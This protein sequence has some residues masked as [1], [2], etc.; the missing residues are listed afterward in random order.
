MDAS[1]V[2]ALSI[3]E[4]VEAD[5]AILEQ[6]RREDQTTRARMLAQAL[7][8]NRQVT[9]EP[10]NDQAALDEETLNSFRLLNIA[11]PDGSESS[12]EDSEEVEELVAEFFESVEVAQHAEGTGDTQEN[13]YNSDNTEDTDN[14]H[15]VETP[16]QQPEDVSAY[17]RRDVS[18]WSPGDDW[19]HAPERSDPAPKSKQCMV[20]GNRYSE[21]GTFEA[22]CGCIWCQNCLVERIEL[23]M[24]DESCFPPECCGPSTI[25]IHYWSP[26]ISRKLLDR[27]LE[28]EVEFRTAN[29]IYCSDKVCS[30]FITPLSIELAGGI[31]RCSRCKKRTCTFCKQDW[32]EGICPVEEETQVVLRLAE[33]EG[34][35]RC[36]KCHHLIE[37]TIG[38]YHM[39]K[40]FHSRYLTI[41][42]L[43]SMKP[44]IAAISSA[45]S[46]V[47]AGRIAVVYIK[48]RT[49]SSI[50]KTII[51]IRKTRIQS[52]KSPKRG[53]RL[54]HYQ[55]SGR[56]THEKLQTSTP[57]EGIDKLNE[58]RT[59][60]IVNISVGIF[61]S[62]T[63]N[64][65]TAVIS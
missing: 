26:L 35:R 58:K 44:A 15:E 42:S 24:R 41:N 55:R 34:W 57:K 22:R 25:L 2:L 39:S 47:R 5:A 32:H 18:G 31:A 19:A 59:I 30:T 56:T 4:A 27:Y 40:S 29:R 7:E 28:K 1:Q 36:G 48:M 10:L 62:V 38:C 17:R 21:L 33:Q 12:H 23:S 49:G 61:L 16:R 11:A 13:E 37:L 46:V 51:Q 45:T 53:R 64:A 60:Q 9:I 3:A 6:Y 43:T 8:E 65:M 50:R 52:S 54:D 14:T 63:I 20:C